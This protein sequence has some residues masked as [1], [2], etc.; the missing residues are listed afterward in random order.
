[1]RWKYTGRNHP[2]QPAQFPPHPRVP[3]APLHTPNTPHQLRNGPP[4][5]EARFGLLGFTT[6]RHKPLEMSSSKGLFFYCITCLKH[7][8]GP[9][10]SQRNQKAFAK[11]DAQKEEVTTPFFPSPYPPPHPLISSSGEDTSAIP[12]AC[13]QAR[14]AFSSAGCPEPSNPAIN[15]S[16]PYPS[17]A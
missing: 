2:Y 7:F 8:S 6:N 16:S 14:A 15:T 1:M 3:H 12:R 13:A 11:R 5:R 4:H 9:A 10:H 17:S